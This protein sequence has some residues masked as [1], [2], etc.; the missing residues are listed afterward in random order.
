LSIFYNSTQKREKWQIIDTK[1]AWRYNLAMN[2]EKKTK[3]DLT[4]EDLARMM[5]NGFERTEKQT[6]KKIEELAMMITRSLDGT[7]E[8]INENL[9]EVKDELRR[10]IKSSTED[11]KAEI[12][13]KVDVF[14]HNDLKYRMEKLEKKF[15]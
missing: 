15:A 6:D 7:N 3:K 14:T 5:A 4:N 8:K 13:K 9:K 11:I 12:N 10:E 1:T 2:D